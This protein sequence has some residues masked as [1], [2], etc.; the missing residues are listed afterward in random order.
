MQPPISMRIPV[1]GVP[2]LAPFAPALHATVYLPPASRMNARKAEVVFLGA[3]GTYD[4]SYW[5]LSVPGHPRYAYS[6]AYELTQFGLMVVCMDHVGTGKSIAPPD[7]N[8]LTL[9]V[10]AHADAVATQYLLGALREGTLIEA[11]SSPFDEVVAVRFGHSLGAML[12]LTEQ[13]LWPSYEG[14]GVLGWA[15]SNP[16]QMAEKVDAL[17]SILPV[18]HGYV[19]P[20]DVRPLFRP[21]FYTPDV[22]GA[23]IEADEAAASACPASGFVGS[24]R[25]VLLGVKNYAERIDCPV[26]VG[27]GSREEAFVGD[28]LTQEVG[29]YKVARHRGITFYELEGSSHCHALSPRR[30]QMTRAMGRWA[31]MVFDGDAPTVT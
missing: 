3:G 30:E 12:A 28:D 22:P 9:E 8:I 26:F 10:M 18:H 2:E 17:A 16:L 27:F 14:L 4:S 11:L 13:A 23:V 29:V 15:N 19:L 20:A 24:T 5:D 1:T 6:V 31:R 21:L 25:E 7:G